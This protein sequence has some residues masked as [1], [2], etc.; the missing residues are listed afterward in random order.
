M[1]HVITQ[2]THAGNANHGLKTGEMSVLVKKTTN[3]LQITKYNILFILAYKI[4]EIPP[5]L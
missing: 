3:A 4:D 2:K 1:N 5:S